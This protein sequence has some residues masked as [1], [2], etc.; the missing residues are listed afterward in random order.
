GRPLAVTSDLASFWNQVYPEVRKEMQG[1]YP[2]HPWP[3]DPWNAA[4]TRR[5]KSR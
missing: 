4:P 3:E 2:K 1:R 5:I